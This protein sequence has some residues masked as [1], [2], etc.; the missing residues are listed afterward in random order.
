[1]REFH[2]SERMIRCLSLVQESQYLYMYLVVSFLK[3][4]VDY[5]FRRAIFG[6]GM[7]RDDEHYCDVQSSGVNCF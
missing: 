7:G 5:V 2:P 1:M 6:A 3:S 4:R